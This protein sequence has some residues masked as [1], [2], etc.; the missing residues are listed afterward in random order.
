MKTSIRR[1]IFAL[2]AL[3]TLALCIAT[4]NTNSRLQTAA[5]REQS[6]QVLPATAYSD[7]VNGL[8][9]GGR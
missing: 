3:V 1:I 7:L 9:T 6:G 8:S 5:I 2:V 4:T